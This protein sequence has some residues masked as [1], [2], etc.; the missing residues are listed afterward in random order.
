M[1]DHQESSSFSAVL[2]GLV[3]EVG[4]QDRRAG[5]EVN[6]GVSDLEAWPPWAGF[7]DTG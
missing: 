1:L 5:V 3:V 6:L 7:S 4:N 2:I